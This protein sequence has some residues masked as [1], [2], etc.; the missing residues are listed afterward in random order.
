MEP[1]TRLCL[2][3]DVF[4]K[5]VH[6]CRERPGVKMVH[7]ADLSL[8]ER[9]GIK[10]LISDGEILRGCVHVLLRHYVLLLQNKCGY[11]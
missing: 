9:P 3:V 4:G 7:L 10:S 11:V 1:G 5:T 2:F 8:R 6:L